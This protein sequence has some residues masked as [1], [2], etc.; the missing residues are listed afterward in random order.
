[1]KRISYDERDAG[2]RQVMRTQPAWPRGARFKQ[3][4]REVGGRSPFCQVRSD[5]K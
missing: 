4:A 3:F 2:L 5:G 1:M